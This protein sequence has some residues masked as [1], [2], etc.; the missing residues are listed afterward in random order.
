MY[1]FFEEFP[2]DYVKLYW[3]IFSFLFIENMLIFALNFV[4]VSFFFA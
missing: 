2:F 4:R 3:K 1:F